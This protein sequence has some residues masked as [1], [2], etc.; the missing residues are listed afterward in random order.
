MA[1]FFRNRHSHYTPPNVLNNE[2]V[3]VLGD[4]TSNTSN[5]V[6]DPVA[7]TNDV[8]TI[9]NDFDLS[10]TVD[11]QVAAEPPKDQGVAVRLSASTSNGIPVVYGKARLK[12]ATFFADISADNKRIAVLISVCEGPVK[13]ISNFVYDGLTLTLNSSTGV[14]TSAVDANDNPV[15]YLNGKLKIVAKTGGGRSSEMEAFSTRW[16]EGASNRTMPNLAY[17]FVELTYDRENDITGLSSNFTFDVEGRTVRTFNSSGNLSTAETYSTNPA[18]CLLDYMTNTRYGAGTVITD[19]LVNLP[20]LYAHSVFCDEMKTYIDTEGEEATAKR[21]TTNGYVNTGESRDVIIS[22]FLQCS[23]GILTYDAGLFKVVSDKVSASVMTFNDDNIYGDVSRSEEGFGSKLNKVTTYYSSVNN[24]FERDEIILSTPTALLNTNEP[25]LSTSFTLKFAGNNIE[26]TRLGT[27]LLNKSRNSDTIQFDTDYRAFRLQANDVITVSRPAMGIVDKLYRIILISETEL[28]GGAS[29]LN[30]SAQEY[31]A[32][33]YDDLSINEKDYAPNFSLPS[34]KNIPAVGDLQVTNPLPSAAV[35]HF[36]LSFTIPNALVDRFDIYYA[37]TSNFSQAT[38]LKSETSS[39]TSFNSGDTVNVTITSLQ[40]GNWRFW[41]VCRNSVAS[42]AQ[43]N[44]L[45]YPWAPQITSTGQ[46]VSP[47]WSKDAIVV[48]EGSSGTIDLANATANFEVH[49]NGVKA[50]KVAP[51]VADSALANGQWK[52]T[53][54]VG[55]GGVTVTST[56]NAAT[57]SVTVTTTNFTSNGSISVTYTYRNDEGT[58]QTGL[59]ASIDVTE[60]PA[61]MDGASGLTS[62]IDFAYAD[63]LAGTSGFSISDSSKKFRGTNAVSYTQGST[64]PPASN[65]PGDYEWAQWTGD[66]GGTGASGQSTDLYRA[67]ANSANGSTGFSTTYFANALYEGTDV[68][69]WTAPA[70]KPTQSNSASSYEWTRIRG[71]DGVSI[72]GAEGDTYREV[73]LYQNTTSA[74]SAPSAPTTSQ[75]FSSSTGNP[76]ATGSWTISSSAPAANQFTWKA[77]LTIRQTNGTGSWSAVDSAWNRVRETGVKGDAGASVTGPEGDSYREIFLYANGASAPTL[78]SVSGSFNNNGT[79]QNEDGW[80]TSA[81]TPGTNQ[82]TW[83]TSLTLIQSNSTGNW[84]NSDSSWNTAVRQ[85]GE[86]GDKGADGTGATGARGAGRW[87]IGVSSF[88]TTSSQVQAQWNSAG[89]TPSQQVEFDQIWFYKGTQLNPTGLEVWVYLG[90]TWN[91]QAAAIDGDFLVDGTVTSEQIKSRTIVSGDIKSGT[92]TANEINTA[93]ITAAVVTADSVNAVGVTAGSLEVGNISNTTGGTPASGQQGANFNTNGSFTIGNNDTFI[94]KTSTGDITLGGELI[95]DAN[96]RAGVFINSLSS[97]NATVNYTTGAYDCS[98]IINAF[99]TMTGEL[100][101]GQPNVT[102]GAS[103]RINGSTIA[104]NSASFRY[105]SED[106]SE[107]IEA[108]ISDSEAIAE[109]AEDFNEAIGEAFE[110]IEEQSQE[111]EQYTDEIRDTFDSLNRNIGRWQSDFRAPN[112]PQL[113]LSR[114]TFTRPVFP[115][116][117]TVPVTAVFNASANTTYVIT[118]SGSPDIVTATTSIIEV[119][120]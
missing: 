64:P 38:I 88:P 52:T 1:I 20:S 111:L 86:K 22:D 79:A 49:V 57:D 31:A 102:A 117:A 48:S 60:A 40:A 58:L 41:V 68:V 8:I 105:G 54:I 69:T 3:D 103:L 76:S 71:E 47:E 81:S 109:W 65:A 56:Q 43:S 15:T 85:T 92:I 112:L 33:V 118:M 90:S 4:T 70:S 62:R 23:S 78:P 106:L 34:A 9:S 116:T 17:I 37:T 73:V 89:A 46:L 59:M 61:G 55:S 42:S 107:A 50:D 13:S 24:E 39:T 18:E 119:K 36:D 83:R 82:F 2:P 94:R 74:T 93:S 44:T 51:S 110:S 53:N 99:A 67:W 28:D 75:G 19:S 100:T 32:E 113:D 7:E 21:Y 10:Y 98:L 114:Y 35:P 84:T 104:S 30:I 101:A 120:R 77:N 6:V 25:E 5:P 96:V 63:N 66:A 115:F 27:I 80:T 91:R 29:G 11:E 97:T 12:G 72:T 108:L 95:T 16:N 87:D 26:A 14:V 45:V